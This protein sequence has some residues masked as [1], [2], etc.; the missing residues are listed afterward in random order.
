MVQDHEELGEVRAAPPEPPALEPWMQ[1]LVVP[2][3]RAR[4]LCCT[5]EARDRAGQGGRT[6]GE[7]LERCEGPTCWKRP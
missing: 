3:W 1:C 6:Q 5:Q 2:S 4:R 7:P